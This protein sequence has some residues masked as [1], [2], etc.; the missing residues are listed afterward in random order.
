MSTSDSDRNADGDVLAAL[1]YLLLVY[2]SIHTN[3]RRNTAAGHWINEAF[4]I[5]L[6]AVLEAHHVLDESK[7][8]D[9]SLPG[10]RSVDL[11]R[12]L[13]QKFAHATGAIHDADAEKLDVA[14][15]EHYKLGDQASLFDGKFI[16]SKD[17]V[18]RPMYADCVAYSRA[19]LEKESR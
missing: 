2:A 7:S 19:V 15:R 8:I 9:K 11:C 6:N 17:T 3:D 10:A 14:M 5:R 12:R 1:E 18:L 4:V 13:R 16:M